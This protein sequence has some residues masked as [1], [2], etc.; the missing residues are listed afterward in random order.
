[1][2]FPLRSAQIRSAFNQG[3][4]LLTGKTAVACMG[5]LLTLASFSLVHVISETL[6]GAYTTQ[7]EAADACQ[8]SKPDLLFVTENLEQGYGLSLAR[9]VKEFSPKTR[10]LVFLHRETQ[11]VVREAIDAL[12]EGVIFISSLGKGRW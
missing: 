6:I 2:E 5:D 1:M 4:P 9:L 8:R 7:N 11:E 12:A 3:Q 10:S